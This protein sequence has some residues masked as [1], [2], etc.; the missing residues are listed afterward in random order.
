[1][2]IRHDIEDFGK[3]IVEFFDSTVNHYPSH[4]ALVDGRE[5]YT[6][7]A[8]SE[9]VK[10]VATSFKEDPGINKGDRIAFILKNCKEYVIGFYAAMRIGAIAVPINV[11]L[12]PYEIQYELGDCSPSLLIADVAFW[13]NLK[14]IM[15]K[16]RTCKRCILVGGSEGDPFSDLVE[17]EAGEAPEIEI[18]GGDVAC[19]MYTSGTTGRP[20]GALVTHWNI[21]Y[22]CQVLGLQ[23]GLKFLCSVPIFHV[24]GLYAALNTAGKCRSDHINGTV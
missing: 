6:Y 7:Q 13:D 5:R 4:T 8:L 20:K 3:T 19:I 17:R 23:A 14:P 15:G 18:E 12:S 2:I 10:S 21:A 24:T 22:S 11:R 1:M 9:K 16:I